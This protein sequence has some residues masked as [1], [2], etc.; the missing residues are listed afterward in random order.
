MENCIGFTG[1][2]ERVN[3]FRIMDGLLI[4]FLTAGFMELSCG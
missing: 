4:S 2:R 1:T 3:S